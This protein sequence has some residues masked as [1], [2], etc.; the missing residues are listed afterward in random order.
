MSLPRIAT[1]IVVILTA[2]AGH[3]HQ[4]FK[5]VIQIVTDATMQ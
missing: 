3:M 1:E 5:P 2:V 4:W